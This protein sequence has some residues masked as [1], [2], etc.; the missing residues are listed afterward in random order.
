MPAPI[1]PPTVLVYLRQRT[2]G[3]RANYALLIEAAAHFLG[4]QHNDI[5]IASEC[6]QCGGND[7]GVPK[8]SYTK[9]TSRRRESRPLPLVSLSRTEGIEAVAIASSGRVG[10]DVESI[11]RLAIADIDHVAFH[12]REQSALRL[13][14]VNDQAL[15]RTLL[16]TAK[17]SILKAAGT[18][19]AI[20]PERLF[21]TFSGTNVT[22]EEW[23]EELGLN[24]A[25]EI[26]VMQLAGTHVCAVAHEPG[27]STI[28]SWWPSGATKPS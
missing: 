1:S 12:S 10:V 25:P 6:S 27:A 8:V 17:E 3:E 16:W 18:G 26:T 21:C 22:L 28:F 19:L 24:V 13:L 2:P 23:P 14:H 11:E 9:G 4:V 5:F 15:H 20:D 7:H